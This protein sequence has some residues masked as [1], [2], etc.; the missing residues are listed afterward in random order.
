MEKAIAKT[1]KCLC[2]AELM[3]AQQPALMQAI[4]VD[5]YF[6]SQKA[7]HN[8]GWAVAKSDFIEH[9]MH[10]WAAGFKA[11]YCNYA[12]HASDICGVKNMNGTSLK[13][14]IENGEDKKEYENDFSLNIETHD[15]NHLN[16]RLIAERPALIEAIEENKYF[17]FLKQRKEHRMDWKESKK[18]F[19]EHFGKVWDAGFRAAYCGYYCPGNKECPT[20]PLNQKIEETE[21]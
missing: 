11:G 8:V 14:L 18:D 3:R 6:L 20:N 17:N 2:L 21:Q 19:M 1:T 15:C 16:E 9:Y 12:C 13:E 5:K 10:T 4:E 7:K